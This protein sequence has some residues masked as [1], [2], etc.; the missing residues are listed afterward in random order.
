MK[1]RIKEDADKQSDHSW[2]D[3]IQDLGLF[4][5]ATQKRVHDGVE[6]SGAHNIQYTDADLGARDSQ[7]EA[8]TY[9]KWDLVLLHHHVLR[10]DKEEIFMLRCHILMIKKS[11]RI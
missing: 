5:W 8:L 3:V 11:A 2:A 6:D 10:I 1:P 4:V 9:C 7:S